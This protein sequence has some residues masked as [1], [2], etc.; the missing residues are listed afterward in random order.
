MVSEGRQA[1]REVWWLSIVPGLTIAAVVLAFNFI[2]DWLRDVIDP[3]MRPM[4]EP[5]VE[6]VAQRGAAE[7]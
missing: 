7:V 5:G 4:V 1:L 2:G 3:N 6:F